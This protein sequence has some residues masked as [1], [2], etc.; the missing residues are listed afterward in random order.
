MPLNPFPSLSPARWET[1]LRIARKFGL[2]LPGRHRKWEPLKINTVPLS[3]P[4]ALKKNNN[5]R[6]SS[7]SVSSLPPGARI[8]RVGRQSESAFLCTSNSINP[9]TTFSLWHPPSARTPLAGT[10]Q[11]HRFLRRDI[12]CLLALPRGL[13]HVASFCPS[14]PL[15]LHSAVRQR[16]RKKK[17]NAR[18]CAPWSP[19][20][21]PENNINNKKRGHEGFVFVAYYFFLLPSLTCL[22]GSNHATASWR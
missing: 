20:A 19:G 8:Q 2:S 5:N 15:I 3:V 12:Q 17:R 11:C 7:W 14:I 22:F 4:F 6:G 10:H 9:A 21:P 1:K 18:A 13:S 16:T